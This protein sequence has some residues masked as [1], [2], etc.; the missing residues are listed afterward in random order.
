MVQIVAVKREFEAGLC[1]A[2]TGKL[3]QPSSKWVPFSNYGR[4][5]Q[6]KE[7]DGLCFHQLCPRY[8]RTLTPTARTAIRLWETFTVYIK[9][10]TATS[11]MVWAKS[12]IA[13][14]CL[15]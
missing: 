7:R 4:P 5:R 6:R 14:A 13:I 9:T 3:C 10:G 15:C 12:E 1:H 8:S 11:R 2:T